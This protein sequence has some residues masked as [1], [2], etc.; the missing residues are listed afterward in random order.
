MLLEA[1]GRPDRPGVAA[2]SPDAT[3]IA[4]GSPV[5][6][7]AASG[8]TKVSPPSASP[9]TSTPC[10]HTGSWAQCSVENRLRQSGFVARFM[11]GE[12]LSRPGF[13]VT[14]LV[15][16]LGGARLEVF[17]YPDAASLARDMASMDTVR[18]VPPGSPSQWESTPL[19]IRSGNLAAVLITQNQRQAERLALA[20]TAGAPQPGSPR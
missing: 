7:T 11:K 2:D 4:Q 6:P 9:V 5:A 1:C 19:L 14:P 10:P 17:L 8:A 20:L 13:S 12:S 3:V 15:Y 16:T 18:V